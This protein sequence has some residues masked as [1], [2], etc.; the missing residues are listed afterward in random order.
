MPLRWSIAVMTVMV[1]A[2]WPSAASAAVFNVNTTTDQADAAQDGVCD[3]SAATAGEQ[4]TLRAAMREANVGVSL[5]RINIPAGTYPL[6]SQVAFTGDVQIVGAGARSTAITGGSLSFAGS[7]TGAGGLCSAELS[8]LTVRNG[9]GITSRSI[10][11]SE[12]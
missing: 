7:C 5:D 2:L 8:N 12:T 6:G 4:C 10:G 11:R 1:A 9:G 3:A